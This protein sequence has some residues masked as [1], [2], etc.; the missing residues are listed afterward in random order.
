MVIN[1]FC[2]VFLT[3]QNL[4]RNKETF[5][6][7]LFNKEK[8]EKIINF[9]LTEFGTEIFTPGLERTRPIFESY[10]K[11]LKANGT[12]VVTIGGTNGKGQTAHTLSSLLIADKQRV[13]L[14][15]SPHILSIKERF[16]FGE[17]SESKEISYEL[18]SESMDR[19]FSKLKTDFPS[20]RISF[21]EFFFMV[22]LDLA[23]HERELDYLIL[24][25]GLGGKLDA[26]NI[27]DTDCAVITSISRD[28]QAIL[29]H[30]YDGILMEKL[31]ITRA[32]GVLFSNLKLQY[33]ND[34]TAR[35]TSQ[36][37][38]D[39]RNLKKEL[40]IGNYFVENQQLALKVF[41]FLRPEARLDSDIFFKSIPLYKGRRE[42][43]TFEKKS[44]I[45]I[46]AHNTDGIRR[47]LESFEADFKAEFPQSLLVSFSQRPIDEI[48]TMASSLDEFFANKCSVTYTSFSHPK[49]LD[50]KAIRDLSARN[51]KGKTNFVLDWK[52]ELINRKEETILVCGSYY[53]IGEVQRFILS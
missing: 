6:S 18:L 40:E 16:L 44:L 29:G 37:S 42:I 26:V 23:T 8:E 12:K 35:Y 10:K 39:W 46:G 38:I 14:W 17:A 19:A 5:M 48:N 24:E 32:H 1:S 20:T 47:M 50:E 7:E 28:H 45:F 4:R 52:T 51:Y 33:L 53:F 22:F 2:G 3:A 36:H 49:A 27:F 9:V 34:L 43:M 15:T 41:E 30:R 13:G 31:G 25:V 21:Y 11:I